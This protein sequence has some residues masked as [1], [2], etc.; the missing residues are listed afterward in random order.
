MKFDPLL[1]NIFKNMV[2]EKQYSIE[3][4]NRRQRINS[5]SYINI[6][7]SILYKLKSGVSLK[8]IPLYAEYSCSTVYNY[9]ILW[10]NNNLFYD[11]WK[12]LLKNERIN[13]NWEIQSIDSTLIKAIR[14]GEVIGKNPCDRS[15]NGCKISSLVDKYG[16][17]LSVFINTANYSDSQIV[18]E[19]VDNCVTKR[20]KN[21]KQTICL[22]KGYDSKYNRELLK[23][24]KYNPLIPQVKRKNQ[25]YVSLTN[26]ELKDYTFRRNVEQYIAI[27]KKYK[28]FLVRFE[29]KILHFYNMVYIANASII[30]KKLNQ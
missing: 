26:E 23:R 16:I 1:L 20:P 5:N 15:R 21:V 14:G 27:L 13:I 25:V 22:D 19:V 30:S 24:L 12:Q 6:F 7:K 10:I 3:K 4:S 11:L 29:R 8:D 18:A 2:N 28:T 9:F 17:P